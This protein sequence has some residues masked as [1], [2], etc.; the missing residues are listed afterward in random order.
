[1]MDRKNVL[2]LYIHE[3]KKSLTKKKGEDIKLIWTDTFGEDFYVFRIKSE[4]LLS[5]A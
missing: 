2:S 1:M 4:I 5:T 3:K